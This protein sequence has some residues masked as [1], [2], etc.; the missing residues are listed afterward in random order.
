MRFWKRPD[1]PWAQRRRELA[2]QIAALEREIRFLE[3]QLRQA[4]QVNSTETTVM[5]TPKPTSSEASRPADASIHR[6]RAV[7]HTTPGSPLMPLQNLGG[8]AP[9]LYNEHGTPRFDLPALWRSLRDK[10]RASTPANPELLKLLAAGGSAGL[11][12]LR[13]ERR[14]A[15]NRFLAL[16]SLL[17]LVIVGIMLALRRAV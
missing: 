9:H 5:R 7:P 14:I 17:L 8:L 6:A 1:D 15:R 3:E 16:L 12:P 10:L 13:Y 11:R 4:G 2:E